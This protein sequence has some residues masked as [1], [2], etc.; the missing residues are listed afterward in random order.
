MKEIIPKFIER[1]VLLIIGIPALFIVGYFL[2]LC[3]HPTDYAYFEVGYKKK[4][5]NQYE[6]NISKEKVLNRLSPAHAFNDTSRNLSDSVFSS[7]K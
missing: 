2:F 4:T 1:I 5:G 6:L 3:S 7:F